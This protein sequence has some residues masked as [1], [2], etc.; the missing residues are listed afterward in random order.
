MSN[1]ELITLNNIFATIKLPKM[2]AADLF[3]VLSAKMAISDAVEAVSKK[4]EGFKESLKPEGVDEFAPDMND[5]RVQQW[6]K[7][8]SKLYAQLMQ[9]ESKTEIEP[10]IT[11]EMLTEMSEGMQVASVEMLMRHLVIK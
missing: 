8:F 2:S 7:A 10:C 9:E 3:R 11:K 5:P 6:D 4:A 1:A